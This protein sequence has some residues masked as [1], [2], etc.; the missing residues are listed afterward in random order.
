MSGPA[1]GELQHGDSVPPG[2]PA[3]YGVDMDTLLSRPQPVE[4]SGGRQGDHLGTR[5]GL[6]RARRPRPTPPSVPGRGVPAT[7]A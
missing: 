1:I 5:P 2:T 6:R 7:A 4:C 3:R